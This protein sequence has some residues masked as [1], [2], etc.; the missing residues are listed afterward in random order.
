MPAWKAQ[1]CSCHCW[2]PTEL[3]DP[4]LGLL[5]W[6]GPGWWKLWLMGCPKY[7]RCPVRFPW[8]SHVATSW[9]QPVQAHCAASEA[10]AGH[11]LIFLIQ[12]QGSSTPVTDWVTFPA[13]LTSVFTFLNKIVNLFYFLLRS[14]KTHLWLLHTYV[15][16]RSLPFTQGYQ[17]MGFPMHGA[18]NISSHSPHVLWGRGE[19]RTSSFF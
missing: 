17:T 10:R 14:T 8:C 11:S 13:A 9:G 3:V 12:I 18:T 16:R 6:A 7:Q 5:G 15:K 2:D 4:Y 1:Q 19:G